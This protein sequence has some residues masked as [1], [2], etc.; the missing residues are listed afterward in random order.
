[1]TKINTM[2]RIKEEYIDITRNPTRNGIY[3]NIGLRDEDNIFQWR[4]TFVGPKDTSYKAGIFFV[5]INFPDD[6]PNS[7]PEFIFRT[8]IYHLNVN[9]IKSD[10]PGA[11][12]LGHVFIS[13]SNWWKTETPIIDALMEID[14]LFHK[15]DPD[16]PY[17]LDR[18]DEFKYN[19]SLYEEKIKYFTKKY[20]DPSNLN[21]EYF[22]SWE[23]SCP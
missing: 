11:A 6:Y 23:F 22:E 7:P 18:V 3:F 15:A 10:K 2:K 8:P 14:K 12:P 16:S 9:P 21:K 19:N 17:G 20:A 1:M 4:N 5:D 13:N